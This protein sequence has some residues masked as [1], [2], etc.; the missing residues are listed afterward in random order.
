[1]FFRRRDTPMMSD[2]TDPTNKTIN[3]GWDQYEHFT[4]VPAIQRGD[5]VFISGIT[6]TDPEGNIV[7]RGDIVA[8]T[9]YVFEKLRHLLTA[10]GGGPG[11]IV[12]TTDYIVDTENYRQTAQVR[13]EFFGG[14]F[15]AATGVVVK[16]LLRPD[17]LIEIDAIAVVPRAKQDVDG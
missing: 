15:P 3:P 10:A 1:V 5:L 11:D 17:A 12:M 6:A 9:R 13:R 4:F 8:Q 16:R 2:M 7:G 14:R